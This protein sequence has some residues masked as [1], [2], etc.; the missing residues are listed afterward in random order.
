MQEYY[1]I[2]KSKLNFKLQQ[3]VVE[4]DSIRLDGYDYIRLFAKP[5]GRTI[6]HKLVGQESNDRF[7]IYN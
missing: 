7:I 6:K 3:T 4:G 2:L 1:Y 5:V